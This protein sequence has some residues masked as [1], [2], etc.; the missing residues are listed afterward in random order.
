[1]RHQISGS[2]VVALAA[3]LAG[4]ALA[5]APA[6]PAASAAPAVPAAGGK[7]T[8]PHN[9]AVE[10]RLQ[11]REEAKKRRI[12]DKLVDINS[13]SKKELKTLPGIGDAEADKII[14]NRPYLTK[15][16]LVSKGVLGEGPYLALRDRMIAF[17]KGRTK[18][19]KPTGST[20]A[21]QAAHARAASAPKKP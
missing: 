10:R 15:T 2:I 16:D 11:A 12:F 5:A 8:A 4:A 14:Q 3:T 18:I 20:A 19:A 13:A 1:M 6:G 9:P 7:A 17:Q 21:P